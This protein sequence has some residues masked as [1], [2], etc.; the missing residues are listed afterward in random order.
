MRAF[1]RAPRQSVPIVCGTEVSHPDASCENRGDHLL[2][3]T[4]QLKIRIPRSSGDVPG[5][6]AYGAQRQLARNRTRREERPSIWIEGWRSCAWQLAR[7]DPGS[8][9]SRTLACSDPQACSRIRAKDLAG[10]Y[11]APQR[12]NGLVA[13]LA[14]NDELAYAVHSGLGH[15]ACAERVAAEHLRLQS[16]SLGCALEELADGVSV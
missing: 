10:P 3:C 1:V 6:D 14:H 15:A 9:F 7:K 5:P 12:R 8:V 13:R 11:I 4:Q 16:G 2:E